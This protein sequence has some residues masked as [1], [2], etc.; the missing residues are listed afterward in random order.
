MAAGR[1][2][3]DAGQLG[4][5]TCTAAGRQVLHMPCKFLAASVC[6]CVGVCVCVR[7]CEAACVCACEAAC[8][9]LVDCLP[10]AR[11]VQRR[12]IGARVTRK[13]RHGSIKDVQT[14]VRQKVERGVR[15]IAR[16][17]RCQQP[18]RIYEIKKI[19]YWTANDL[20]FSE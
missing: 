7:A 12:R 10:E 9:A 18:I 20:I 15:G 17:R 6:A 5:G 2:Q 13:V 1:W 11:Q 3:T 14:S 4:A 19:D 16:H 8:V